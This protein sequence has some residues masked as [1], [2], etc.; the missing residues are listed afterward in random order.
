MNNREEVVTNHHST[1]AIEDLASREH[2]GMV[3]VFAHLSSESQNRTMVF[4][5]S[6]IFRDYRTNKT[7]GLISRNP[8][9]YKIEGKGNEDH[10]QGRSHQSY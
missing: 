3:I 2:E 9:T 6:S 1:E 4:N 7:E 5:F 8:Q 10:V